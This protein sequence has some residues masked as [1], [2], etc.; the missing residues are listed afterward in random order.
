M[1]DLPPGKAR[2]ARMALAVA[3]LTTARTSP[4]D[5]CEVCALIR[6]ECPYHRGVADG[7]AATVRALQPSPDAVL[8][9]LR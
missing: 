5:D 9:A 1:A 3:I 7:I 2:D 4:D 6:A 8:E